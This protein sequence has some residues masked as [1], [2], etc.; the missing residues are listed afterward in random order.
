MATYCPIKGE[1]VVYL[2]CLE[3]ESKKCREITVKHKEEKKEDK[4]IEIKK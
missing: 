1:K 2:E 4:K 3:C